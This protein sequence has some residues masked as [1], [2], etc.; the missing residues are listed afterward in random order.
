MKISELVKGLDVC[1]SGNPETDVSGITYDSRK[2]SAGDL[3]VALHGAKDDGSRYI[4]DA[5]ALG[6]SAVLVENGTV[7]APREVASIFS[8]NAARSMGVMASRI[9]GN[10]SK[11]MKIL[12]VTGTNGK[13]TI[14]Y[15]IEKIFASSGMN[16]G[17]IGTISYRFGDI[18]I[19]APNT[20]PQSSDLHSIL[21]RMKGLG[22]AGAAME[23]SSH[24]IVQDRI[25]GCDIDTAIFTNLTR[26]HLDYHKTMDEYKKAKF[27]LFT[28]VLASSAKQKKFSVINIDDPAGR[29]LAG[30]AAGKVVTYGLTEGCDVY[31][32]GITLSRAGTDFSI[33]ACGQTVLF[34]T[35][36]IGMYN[37]YNVLG[38]VACAFCQD[39]DIDDAALSLESFLPA[40]GRFETVDA[41]QQFMVIVDY[42]HTPDALENVLTAIKA[43]DHKRIITVFGCGGE[44]D[45]SKRPLMGEI[46][47]RLSDYTVI[48]SDNPRSESPERIVLDIEVG[49]QRLANKNYETIIDR[50]EAIKKAVEHCGPGDV[51]LI[52]GKGHE[53]Y[54]IAADKRYHF[55]DREVVSEIIR[56]TQ[57][58]DK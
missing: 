13:T 42:A 45:R 48:T 40:P 19:P 32:S 14:T 58:A 22:A 33:T 11:A 36:L 39:I 57:P 29:E 17:V 10:P 12:A 50:R 25:A 16:L 51:L 7:S 3:F 43:I 56:G 44:R 55:S 5:V 9:Y 18:N 52:A 37:V 4:S 27:L 41:G 24:G 26:D 1:V 28:D 46:S 49:L 54:F 6:A 53:D 23:V 38:A 30:K 31:A 34:K 2:V 8:S 35:K 21:S 15:L 47:A 20:T